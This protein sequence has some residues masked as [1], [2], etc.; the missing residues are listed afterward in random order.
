MDN[1]ELI[2]K[3]KPHLYGMFSKPSRQFELL[4]NNPLIWLPLIIVTFIYIIAS[5]VRAYTVKIDDIM[6]LPGMTEAEGEMVLA[7]AKAFI[8]IS[9]FITP[10]LSILFI[11]ILLFFIIKIMKKN[12]TFLQ[13]FSMNIY[14]SLIG[15]VG[16]LINSLLNTTIDE[17]SYALT[18][19]AG[20]L[21]SNSGLLGAVE[22]FSIWEY[23]L[24]AIGLN[25]IGQFSKRTSIVIVIILF[26]IRIGFVI[27]GEAA[28]TLLHL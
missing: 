21:N 25:K 27:A 8:V 14:I 12:A 17:R 19:L 1:D 15:A 22:L 3:P 18:S 26:L 13:L 7:T 28:S 5:T 2:S 20:I 6:M 23:I 4:K 11:T 9:G 16:L 10:V 24:T